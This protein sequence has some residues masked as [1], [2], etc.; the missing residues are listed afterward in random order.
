VSR[1]VIQG[2]PYVLQGARGL[3][4]QKTP[5]TG[6]AVEFDN[7]QVIEMWFSSLSVYGKAAEG[8]SVDHQ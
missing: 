2:V 8:R 5:G 3:S 7:G 4:K 1:F 6:A